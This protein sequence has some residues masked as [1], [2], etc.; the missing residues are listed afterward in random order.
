MIKQAHRKLDNAFLSKVIAKFFKSNVVYRIL[1]ASKAGAVGPFDGGCLI[2]AQAI[3]AAMADGKIVRVW[4]PIN[5]GQT[6]HYGVQIQGIVFDA[7][8]QYASPAAWVKH[9]AEDTFI[10]DRKPVFKTGYDPKWETST[11]IVSDLV[12]AKKMASLLRA[13][14]V[15][16]GVSL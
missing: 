5:G 11:D 3:L 12:A 16:Q 1:G 9:V 4:S 7:G 15:N 6:E 8:G 13:Y 14:L 2:C 10:T